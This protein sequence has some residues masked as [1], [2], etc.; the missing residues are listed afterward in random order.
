[1]PE[2]V[3]IMQLEESRGFTIGEVLVVILIIALLVAML[4]PAVQNARE[5]SRRASCNNNL[6]RIGLALLLYEEQWKSFPAGTVFGTDSTTP[7]LWSW[8]VQILPYAEFNCLYSDL[9][10][11]G[12]VMSPAN[13]QKLGV[14]EIIP[15]IHCP[16]DPARLVHKEMEEPFA[17]Q[18]ALTSYLGVSGSDAIMTAGDGTILSPKQCSSIDSAWK[19]GTTSG[20]FYG[21]SFVRLRDVSD[22]TSATLAVGER[23]IP[24]DGNRGWWTGPGLAN[25]SPAGWTDVVLPASDNLGLG[26]LRP[27]TGT[28]EDNYHWWGWHPEGISFLFVDG[29]VKFLRYD[30]DREVFRGL[31]T[32]SGEE[33]V[34]SFLKALENGRAVTR[35]AGQPEKAAR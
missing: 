18:W 25:A 1:M 24:D 4:L 30:M 20:M 21:D 35:S 9:D 6:K 12:G 13:R 22:G 16:S 27:R 10:L 29:S 8:Q 2:G 26:G 17:G 23:G 11:A 19:V 7:T 33:Q 15:L 14:G 5:A 34:A 31:S 28:F 32:R 3:L